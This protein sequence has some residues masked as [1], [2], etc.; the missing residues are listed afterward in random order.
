M[1]TKVI[2]L[3]NSILENESGYVA[4][5]SEGW[6][7]AFAPKNNRGYINF[8][9]KHEDWTGYK[10]GGYLKV[11]NPVNDLTGYELRFP[12][13]SEIYGEDN[14]SA[15]RTAFR[16]VL[17]GIEYPGDAPKPRGKPPGAGAKSAPRKGG[18]RKSAGNPAMD[19]IAAELAAM[20]EEMRQLR[21]S[22][23]AAREN[24]RKVLNGEKLETG[25]TPS[26][27]PAP[28]GDGSI[29]L[30]NKAAQLLRMAIS[31]CETGEDNAALA[32]LNALSRIRKGG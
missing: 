25:M 12:P 23:A 22:E 27:G 31:H 26:T 2:A 19:S 5:E 4:F 15:L 20:R 18:G 11:P 8:K 24:L 9:A 10:N 3:L 7:L 14:R 17:A 13:Q 1:N 16:N 28:T 6:N 30:R 21:E 32:A 29:T